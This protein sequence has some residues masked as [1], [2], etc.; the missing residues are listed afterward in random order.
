MVAF[1]LR[2]AFLGCALLAAAAKVQAQPS[3]NHDCDAKDF[4]DPFAV[5]EDL[6]DYDTTPQTTF[7]QP[8]Y[9]IACETIANSI[10][11]ASHVFFPGE[12]PWGF[13]LLAM[14]NSLSEFHLLNLDSLAGTDEFKQDM[15]HWANSSPEVS[16]CSV[17]P[18]TPQDVGLIV[19]RPQQY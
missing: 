3:V 5:E 7:A 12:S 9:R 6:H 19:I 4:E 13:S 11:P 16:A 17:R 15:S 14:Y 18:G 10:S 8:N 1:K 2:A